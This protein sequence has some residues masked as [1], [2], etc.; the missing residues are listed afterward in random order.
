MPEPDPADVFPDSVAESDLPS[1]I[2]DPVEATLALADDTDLLQ[3]TDREL[4]IDTA[5]NARQTRRTMENIEATVRDVATRF[6]QLSTVQ[7]GKAVMGLLGGL[8]GN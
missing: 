8:R 5:L 3:A 2:L 4:L 6:D 1:E 7:K